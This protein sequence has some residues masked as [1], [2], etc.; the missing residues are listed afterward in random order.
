MKH[1]IL[2]C[3][4]AFLLC[5]PCRSALPEDLIGSWSVSRSYNS[6]GL[7]GGPSGSDTRNLQVRK[8]RN[9]TL[10]VVYNEE[11]LT[12]GLL[13]FFSSNVRTILDLRPNG[14]A[15]GHTSINRMR[16]ESVKGTWKLK[17]GTISATLYSSS[18]TGKRVTSTV[19]IRRIGKN[20][21]V[22][23]EERSDGFSATSLATRLP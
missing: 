2:L 3:S 13:G 8:E 12:A 15:T 6:E 18:R 11:D 5:A 9:G 23:E 19:A 17:N 10:R 22:A 14:S 16:T 4:A 7:A 21:L 20:K 1:S